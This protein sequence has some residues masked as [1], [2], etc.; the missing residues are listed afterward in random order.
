MAGRISCVGMLGGT[1]RG[2]DWNG[3]RSR[4]CQAF[5]HQKDMLDP[6]AVTGDVRPPFAEAGEGTRLKTQLGSKHARLLPKFTPAPERAGQ[7]PNDEPER[8]TQEG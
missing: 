3:G 6:H 8:H 2:G 4:Q 1:I 7:P 5:M